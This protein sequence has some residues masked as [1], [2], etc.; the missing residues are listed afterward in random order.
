MRVISLINEKGGV[1][2]TTLAT[3]L[4]AGLALRGYRVV[5]IDAD[6]QGN[7][8]DALGLPL[9]PKLYDLIIRDV[10][11]RDVLQMVH[12]DVY[13]PPNEQSKGTLYAVASNIETR[14]IPTSTDDA[15]RF[16][17]RV[18]E[19]KGRVDFAVIDT[20]PTPSLFHASI[21]AATDWIIIPT[22]C[23][24]F[25][26]L[27]GVPSSL[28]HAEEIRTAAAQHNLNIA[29][30]LAIVPNMYRTRTITHQETLEHLQTNYPSLVT[31]PIR[32]SIVIADATV[33]RQLVFGYAPNSGAAAELWSL[34]DIAERTYVK[35]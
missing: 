24:A 3:H 17:R 30:I 34:V 8:T 4:A 26:S 29:N 2:K 7:A 14:S 13:S 6:P 10:A 32:Q 31:K 15:G 12:P 20:S 28:F 33:Q 35:Q 21:T 23:E 5:M 16:R 18:L 1:G 19:L 22:Q 25:S 27:R 11:W 9:A